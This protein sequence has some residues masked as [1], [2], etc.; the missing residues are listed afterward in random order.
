M[1]E[2]ITRTVE[3]IAK[4]YGPPA[5]GVS[6]EAYAEMLDRVLGKFSDQQI[7]AA[8]SDVG[9]TFV[10]SRAEQWPSPSR[11]REAIYGGP[12]LQDG[13]Q[14]FNSL[15]DDGMRGKLLAQE[16]DARAWAIDRI[17]NTEIGRQSVREGWVKNLAN[18]ARQR[19]LAAVRGSR[20]VPM[21]ET[22]AAGLTAEHRRPSSHLR[23]DAICTLGPEHTALIDRLLAEV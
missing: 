6:A 7:E 17:I 8:L 14:V 2:V 11:F 3:D 15:M 18:F 21:I 4:T 20:P 5:A 12:S 9:A 13:K 19:H 22:V 1:R 16:S 10:A 23:L